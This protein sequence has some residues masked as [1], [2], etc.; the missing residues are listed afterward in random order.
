MEKRISDLMRRVRV[1][2]KT[3]SHN[4][5]CSNRDFRRISTLERKVARLN[6]QMKARKGNAA[7]T[8]IAIVFVIG[9]ISE[10]S[11]EISKLEEKYKELNTITEMNYNSILALEEKNE[12]D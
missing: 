1:L 12:K 2:E 9:C 11:A 7:L 8:V 5:D 10:I 6:R 3:V 4:R